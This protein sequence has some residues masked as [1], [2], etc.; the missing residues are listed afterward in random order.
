MSLFISI[1]GMQSK[2]SAS[3]SNAEQEVPGHI[4]CTITQIAERTL[5]QAFQSVPFVAGVFSSN[6]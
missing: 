1:K 6:A 4:V 5:R 2:V 3:I